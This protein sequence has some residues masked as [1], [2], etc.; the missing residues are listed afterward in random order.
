MTLSEVMKFQKEKPSNKINIVLHMP[1]VSS[2]VRHLDMLYTKLIGNKSEG[3]Q[4]SDD[5]NSLV[6]ILGQPYLQTRA[7]FN[8][9]QGIKQSVAV[10]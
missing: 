5:G 2:M 8:P 3:Q 10:E 9:G 6:E 4:Q 7:W 1:E